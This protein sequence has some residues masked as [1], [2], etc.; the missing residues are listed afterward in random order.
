M[1]E[2][3]TAGNFQGEKKQSKWSATKRKVQIFSC[4]QNET[5]ACIIFGRRMWNTNHVQWLITDQEENKKLFCKQIW[6]FMNL[7]WICVSASIEDGTHHVFIVLVMY[8]VYERSC[9]LFE[10]E[11][12][13]DLKKKF[14]R[15]RFLMLFLG[16]ACDAFKCLK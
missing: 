5:N 10:R 6:K 4:S 13:K 12:K 14:A 8:H 7:W 16:N 3:F 9:L 11:R 15:R 2:E 1:F